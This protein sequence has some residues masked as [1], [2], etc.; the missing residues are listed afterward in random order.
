MAARP[1]EGTGQLASGVDKHRGGAYPLPQAV[2]TYKRQC[3]SSRASFPLLRRPPKCRRHGAPSPELRRHRLTT[4]VLPLDPVEAFR[5]P[6]CPAPPLSSLEPMQRR[7]RRRCLAAGH[8][9]SHLR[10]DRH[11]QSTEGEPKPSPS[12]HPDPVRPPVRHRR[13]PLR[14]QGPI[15]IDCNLCRGLIARCQG[16]NRK[17][18]L[19]P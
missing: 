19:P 5:A 10:R 16:L 6:H 3:Q 7:P 1:G 12:P 18:I 15:C 13:A 8:H 4:L 2:A 11:S 17:M 9:R 14:C